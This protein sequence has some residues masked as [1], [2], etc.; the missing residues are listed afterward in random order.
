LP[1]IAKNL[2]EGILLSE[3]NT[4]TIPPISGAEGAQELEEGQNEDSDLIRSKGYSIPYDIMWK[5]LKGVGS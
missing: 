2:S 3:Q 4:Q 5:N 1:V